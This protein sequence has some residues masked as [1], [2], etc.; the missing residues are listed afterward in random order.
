MANFGVSQI[1]YYIYVYSHP[2]FGCRLTVVTS[3][4]F[5]YGRSGLGERE[6]DGVG[7]GECFLVEVF[8]SSWSELFVE[9][10][11]FVSMFR[12]G[13]WTTAGDLGINFAP[14]TEI[15]VFDMSEDALL[16]IG[17]GVDDDDS[18][19]S[20]G[21]W[22]GGEIRPWLDCRLHGAIGREMAISFG[23]MCG[24]GAFRLMTFSAEKYAAK[25]LIVVN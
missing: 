3:S 17:V 5:R 1:T 24:A 19:W 8:T 6:C 12:L 16:V 20:T 15:S 10:M 22:G 18:F 11:Q 4:I 13:F 21:F 9:G 23:E 25:M 7:D 14:F 2:V